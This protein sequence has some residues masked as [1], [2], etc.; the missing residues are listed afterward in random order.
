MEI[1]YKNLLKVFT[2]FLVL[3]ISCGFA[4]AV[5]DLD[6]GNSA[7]IVDNG[8]LSLSDNMM[9][10]SA[11]NCKNLETIEESHTF[12]EKNTVKDVSYGLSTPIDGNTFEDIQTAIDN[13][14]DGDIIELNG[15]Y[16]GNGSDIKITK[17]L[18][19]SG[20]LETI[21]DAKNKSGIFYVNSNN[22]TLQN[23]KFYNSIV[24]EYGSA[25]HFLSNGS[26]INCTFIN[27]TAG[28]VYGTID[29][30]W[31]TGGV[32]YLAKG[33][34]SVINCT[35]INNTANADGGAIY[36]GVDGGSVI[37]CTFINNTAKELGGAI[38]IGGGHDGGAH[39]SNVYDCY[40]DNCVFINNTAGE[41]A[42]IYYG[43]GGLIFNCTFINN[44]ARFG[45]SI[46]VN[47]MYYPNTVSDMKTLTIKECD[48]KSNKE[49]WGY[50]VV[51]Y[52]A[53]KNTI[54]GLCEIIDSNFSN[55]QAEDYINIYNQGNIYLSGNKISSNYATISNDLIAYGNNA[56][57]TSQ[58]S[59]VILDNTTKSVEKYSPFDVYAVLVDD[60][61][62]YIRDENISLFIGSK[63]VTGVF[64]NVNLFK[65]HLN[66]LSSLNYRT[67]VSGNY[68][69][70]K[71]LVVKTGVLQLDVEVDIDLDYE[72]DNVIIKLKDSEG[73]P[74]SGESVS[75]LIDNN[76]SSVK[77]DSNGEA[78]V[79]VN[80]ISMVKAI[81]TDGFGVNVSSYLVVKAVE[82]VK[83]VP[84]FANAKIS[85]DVE[86][87]CSA[88]I[89][90]LKDLSGNPI[91]SAKLDALVNGAGKTLITNASG[92]AKID[93]EGNATVEVTYIDAENANATVSSSLTVIK[94]VDSV[95]V[96]PNRTAT[97]IICKDMN[98]TAVAKPDGRIGKYFEVTLVDVNGKALANKSVNIGFNGAVYNLTTNETGGAK[99]QINLGYEG[100][101]TFAI[102]FLGDDNYTGSFKVAL[103]SVSKHSPKLS[104]PAKTYKA[105]AKTKTITATFKTSNGNAI[106]GKKISFNINGKTYSGTTNS[107]GVASV[108]IS[109]NKK[110]TYSCTAKYAGDGM[111]KATST[112]F[113]VKIV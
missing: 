54:C 103:I 110:G 73:N 2:I 84:T 43:G 90:T 81:F 75:L 3:L 66:D 25:V 27:N 37:N 93:I 26:V 72:D 61:G 70:A 69:G 38:Y 92:Q 10:E 36:C 22:V 87:N 44:T 60:Q 112:K 79:P 16:F 48:F 68:D 111:Y 113:N 107:K 23:L 109:L 101:Y 17:D 80:E 4:S 105:N 76:T 28:G 34:G 94:N 71:D 6:E 106:S 65:Y 52:K 89:V 9:S 95:P 99:L 5:S 14:A 32:V 40:V 45:D 100:K 88:V 67:L 82:K 97:N 59:L 41:G 102:A 11:D 91:S 53:Y 57:I 31:S 85:L 74:I 56:N 108:K 78:K 55:E 62:N 86:D 96:I 7:N 8:D 47:N 35:F 64:D 98:T 83:L 42:G 12:S 30:F 50:V 24:P 33:N 49:G 13:A 21:L 18:T 77:T 1:R 15:T 20:N 51:N 46:L 19:I 39:Y 58:T 63:N 104:A 29:Y